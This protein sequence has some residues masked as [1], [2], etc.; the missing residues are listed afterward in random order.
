MQW[1]AATAGAALVASLW[2]LQPEAGRVRNSSASKGMAL[3]VALAASAHLLLG[4]LCLMTPYC[5]SLT[6]Q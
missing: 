1:Q 6:S 2:L 4:M 3:G 5:L